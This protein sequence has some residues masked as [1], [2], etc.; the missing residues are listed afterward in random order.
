M[1]IFALL[2]FLL[3][4]SLAHAVLFNGGFEVGLT[5]WETIGDVSTV[6]FSFGIDPPQGRLQVLLTSA[7]ASDCGP[8]PAGECP[9]FEHP[10]SYSGTNS[11]RTLELREFFIGAAS[12]GGSWACG[13]YEGSGIKQTF[14]V[15]TD[16]L[17][18]FTWKF[19]TDE[20]VSPSD[21][22][23]PSQCGCDTAFYVLDN[24]P[25]LAFTFGAPG[26][27]SFSSTPFRF[28]FPY[29][30]TTIFLSA[31]VHTLA[32]GVGD[33]EDAAANSGF[34]ID[35]ISFRAVSE[36]PASLLFAIGLVVASTI[37]YLRKST[38]VSVRP[39]TFPSLCPASSTSR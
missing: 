21:A 36:P 11:V 38:N 37:C 9:Y 7:P 10:Q 3:T 16:A 8:F 33:V 19:V 30:T 26:P 29:Q 6:D 22:G 2:V 25:L 4:P 13:L 15:N 34:L 24:N 39:I 35:D 32:F 31:G 28:E 5:G 1:I 23:W 20:G 27:S 18:S 14:T 12:C 17:M